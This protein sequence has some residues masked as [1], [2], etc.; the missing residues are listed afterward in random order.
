MP[1]SPGTPTRPPGPSWPARGVRAP[2]GRAD[3][4]IGSCRRRRTVVVGF[5]GRPDSR[6]FAEDTV[7]VLAAAGIPV[8]FFPEVTPTP[9]VAFAVVH[10]GA[11]GAVV[12]TASH[13]PRRDNGYKVYDANGAQI[14]PPI[15]EQIAA[16]I[17]PVGP[18]A[19]GP[20]GG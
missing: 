13:N 9:L 7:G 3:H 15:D 16:A 6:R 2:R 5:D 8:R 14:I 17:A 20:R 11:T 10:L 18:A 19:K 1:G 4:V 12:I